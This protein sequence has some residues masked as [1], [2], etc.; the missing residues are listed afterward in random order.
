MFPRILRR[1]RSV[2]SLGELRLMIACVLGFFVNLLL[3][4]VL[5]ALL[6][7]VFGLVMVQALTQDIIRLLWQPLRS[8]PG[9]LCMSC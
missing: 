6:L 8:R 1:F 3:C 9:E 2:F 5:L 7:Y 4:L